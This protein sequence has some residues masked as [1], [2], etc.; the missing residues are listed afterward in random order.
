VNRAAEQ[1][2]DDAGSNGSREA[3]TLQQKGC[4]IDAPLNFEK[5]WLKQSKK[6]SDRK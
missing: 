5:A 1:P 4:A 3:K 6:K 2:Y